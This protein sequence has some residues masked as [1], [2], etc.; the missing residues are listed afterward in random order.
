MKNSYPF[1]NHHKDDLP[2]I[3]MAIQEPTLTYTNPETGEKFT[4]AEFVAFA[5]DYL[6]V[7]VIFWSVEAPWLAG[8]RTQKTPPSRAGLSVGG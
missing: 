2:L 7:D 4:R 6:G 5:R 3:A 8:D 1:F